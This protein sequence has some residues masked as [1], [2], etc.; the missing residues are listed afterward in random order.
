MSSPILAFPTADEYFIL[1]TDACD[2]ALAGILSQVQ[3]GE[4]KVIAYYSRCFS[5]S[6]RSYCT[7]RKELLAVIAS[8]KHFHHYLYGRKFTIRSDHASLK[9]LANFKNLEGQLCRWVNILE[10]YDYEIVH[11]PGRVHDN[12]DALSRRPCYGNLCKYCE[13]VENRFISVN[14]AKT[15]S[16]T[17]D[18]Q[19][20][21]EI[22]VGHD[23]LTSNSSLVYKGNE[24]KTKSSKLECPEM[25]LLFV[26][27]I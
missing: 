8:V 23:N 7:T 15:V 11:R 3:N 13:R 22:K 5:R 18:I 9:W 6:E 12:A 10:N 25:I 16:E 27:T 20:E 2:T 17:V 4:E 1:D 26:V 21:N 14:V 19:K 24:L